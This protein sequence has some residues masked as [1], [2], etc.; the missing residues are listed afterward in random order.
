[1]QILIAVIAALIAISFILQSFD[2]LKPS[3]KWLHIRVSI[4]VSKLTGLIFWVTIFLPK[5]IAM[6]VEKVYLFII[7][8]PIVFLMHTIICTVDSLGVKGSW[9]R[10]WIRY[11][12]KVNKVV[13]LYN[14]SSK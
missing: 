2:S 11:I 7:A 1:M 13:D 10:F 3:F 8:F 9:K 6:L 14:N 5:F 4:M 12:D